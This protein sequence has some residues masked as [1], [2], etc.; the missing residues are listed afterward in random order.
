M[1][2]DE[3]LGMRDAER[4]AVGRDLTRHLQRRGHQLLMRDDPT[5]QAH[6]QRF[7]GVEQPSAQREFERIG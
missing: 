4:R 6:A 7:L 2:I 3:P 1:V 5:Y